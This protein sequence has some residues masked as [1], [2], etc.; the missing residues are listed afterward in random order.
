VTYIPG[1]LRRLVIER[2]QGCCEYCLIAQSDSLYAHEVDHIIPEKHRGRT[3]AD[4][5]C[6]SCLDCNRYKGSDFASFDPETDK[7]I[8]LFHPRRD[9]W[10]DHFRLNGTIIEPLTPTGRVT[11]FILRLN[12]ELRVRQ[13][14]AL[15]SA[16]RYPGIEVSNPRR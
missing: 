2:A 10:E 4:N 9:V 1:A 15:L 8:P 3:D 11:V 16:K 5:L 13:R 12:D 6:L 7:I 14:A